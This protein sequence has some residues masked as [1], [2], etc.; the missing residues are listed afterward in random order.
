MKKLSISARDATLLCLVFAILVVF[1]SYQYGWK[2]FNEKTDAVN[3]EI[4]ALQ[5]KYDDLYDKFLH[6]KEYEE[7]IVANND[8][9]G[10]IINHFDTGFSQKESLLF[11]TQMEEDLDVWFST[12]GLTEGTPMYR[13]GAVTSTNPVKSGQNVYNTDMMGYS[14]TTTYSYRCSYDSFKDM[15]DYILSHETKYKV[16][17][18]SASYSA[19]DDIVSGAFSYT[20]YAITGSERVHE[21]EDIEGIDIGTENLF[22]SSTFVTE[23]VSTAGSANSILT[24]YDL[25][26]TLSASTSDLSSVVVGR[27]AIASSQVKNNSNDFAYVNVKITGEDG[28]YYINYEVAGNKYPATNFSKGMSFNPG[29]T[30]DLIVFSSPRKDEEDK[31]GAYVSIVNNTDLTLNIKV[32]DDDTDL[33][34]FNL[35]TS[36]GKINIVE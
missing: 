27:R 2:M 24:N 34:R 32:M 23:D 4:K 28:T 33:P 7:K 6:I 20:Q 10:I 1:L 35:R 5:V 18:I 29:K 3:E 26:I 11:S 16:D 19:E 9:Y 12:V 8:N 30:L 13:F 21:V 31:A 22:A 17:G 36:E 25:A 15:V 14:K